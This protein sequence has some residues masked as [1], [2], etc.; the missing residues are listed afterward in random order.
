MNKKMKYSIYM[1]F[2]LLLQNFTLKAQSEFNIDEAVSYAIKNHANV[3]NSLVAIQDAELQIK[4][5]KVTGLPQINGQFGYT[6]NA[7]IP[8][9]LLDAKNFDP[10]AKEG[11]VVKFKFGVR[12]AGQAGIGINQLIF[13]ATWLVGLR[14]A[15]T[16]RLMAAQDLQKTKVDIA[17]NVKKAYY[18]VLV[19][20]SRATILD[21]NISRLD[22]AIYITK[23]FFKQGFVE[24]ID[25]SRLS[26]QRNN[27]ITEKQKINN[28]ISLSVQ[29]LKFQMSYPVRQSITLTEK[30]NKESVNALKS[31]IVE[32]VVVDNRIE[33]GQLKTSRNLT[34]LN[35]ERIHKGSIPSVFFSGSLGASHSN[36]QFNPFERWFGSSALTLGMKIPI[37]DSGL[38]KVQAQRQNLN[39]IKIDNGIEMLKESFVLQNEQAKTNL[40]NG[41]EGLDVQSRNMEL[42]QEVLD[43]S[44]I[45][46]TQGV[47]S[48]LEIINA[49]LDLKTAQ[50]NYFSALYDVLIAKV[51]L[52]KAQGNLISK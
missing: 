34:L 12:W 17:E 30:L 52:D 27:L 35:I 15:D 6:Y 44:K 28:L 10:T 9:Q 33:L 48:N 13:D 31:L 2:M 21:I 43:V 45:K 24:K 7:I 25:I 51:D 26:V 29:L 36:T 16:Y 19:A 4:E 49:E 41:F 1:G 11:E 23:Q 37:Y 14:A 50:N 39:L 38:R 40:R 18:S 20:E 3:K 46:Y 32:D 5:I 47:G 22:S 42:A 8:S